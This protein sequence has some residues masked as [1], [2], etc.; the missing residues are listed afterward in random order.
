METMI[1]R[2]LKVGKNTIVVRGNPLAL[3]YYKQEFKSDLL[4]DLL[5]MVG[6]MDALDKKGSDFDIS[7]IDFIAILQLVWA[8]AKAGAHGKKHPKFE[9]WLSEFDDDFDMSDP[10]FLMAALE[11]ATQGFFRQGQGVRAGVTE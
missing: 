2:E 11:E 5:A 3:L 8:M 6:G 7:N 1:L 9:T 4:K 10:E